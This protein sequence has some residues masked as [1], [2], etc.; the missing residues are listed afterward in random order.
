MKVVNS[1]KRKIGEF[2]GYLLS[3][4]NVIRGYAV[5]STVCLCSPMGGKSYNYLRV[6]DSDTVMLLVKRP[7]LSA[8][9][10]MISETPA[11]PVTPSP[12]R[13]AW[14]LLAFLSFLI[15]VP[16]AI[17]NDG[18]LPTWAVICSIP[19]CV[20]YLCFVRK[21]FYRVVCC[22]PWLGE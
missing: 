11:T 17:A 4:G 1:D 13:T 6:V 12:L 7:E 3:E 14:Y 19:F 15:F 18:N 8:E 21:N 16:M 22:T 10:E 5:G 9:L 20:W 2:D